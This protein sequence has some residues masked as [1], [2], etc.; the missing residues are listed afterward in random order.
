M[1]RL[2]KAYTL[3]GTVS[4]YEQPKQRRLHMQPRTMRS[5]PVARPP[6]A[7]AT[8]NEPRTTE[9]PLEFA[10]HMPQARSAAVAGSFNKWESKRTPM[11]KDASGDW[12][13]TVWLA[14]GRYEYRF[15]VDGQWV[16][17]PKAKESTPNGFGSTNSVA[18]V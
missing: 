5:T 13:A 2:N 9:K 10:L 14:P 3:L 7:P 18:V 17:D 4:N 12:K 11:H 16:S 1:W 6:M 15:I 8:Q